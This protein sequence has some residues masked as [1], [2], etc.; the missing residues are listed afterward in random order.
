MLTEIMTHCHNSTENRMHTEKKFSAT[1]HFIWT[2]VSF[3]TKRSLTDV[4]AI[5]MCVGFLPKIGYKT[6][7]ITLKV[8][9][10]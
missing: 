5:K 2:P 7:K 6:A 8:F 9:S 3:L 10:L 1:V 4:G